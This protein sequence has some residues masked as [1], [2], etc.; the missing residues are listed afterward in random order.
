MASRALKET[1]TKPWSRAEIA[2]RWALAS[3]PR[4]A[5]AGG[6]RTS[7][8]LKEFTWIADPIKRVFSPPVI[9]AAK[10][11]KT[12]MLLPGFGSHPTRMRNMARQMEAAGHTAKRWGLGFNFGAT[13][14]RFER[15]EKRLCEIYD[16][17]GEPIALVGWSLG[18][19]IAR[20]LAKRHPDKVKL[21]MTLGTPFSGDRRANNAS[22]VYEA[23]NDHS[24]DNPPFE[25]DPKQKPK[26]HTIA[27]WSPYDGVIAPACSRGEAGER[28]IAI[29]VPERHF[30]FSASRRSI[31]RILKLLEEHA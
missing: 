17:A 24:V 22:R 7:L 8:L 14:V 21:V 15:V 2:R 29:E 10:N 12:V 25:D 1:E 23:I 16:R 6:P 4:P 20:E 28:D 11:P 3:E 26:A 9:A 5:D 13:A 27:I 31:N 30:E 18:G 19:V